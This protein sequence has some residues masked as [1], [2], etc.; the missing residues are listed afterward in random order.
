M[1]SS[2]TTVGRTALD[3]LFIV[4]SVWVMVHLLVHQTVNANGEATAEVDLSSQSCK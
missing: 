1:I 4:Y 3:S 2:F